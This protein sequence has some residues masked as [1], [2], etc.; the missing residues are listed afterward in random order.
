MTDVS[1]VSNENQ[2]SSADNSE[3]LFNDPDEMRDA[4]MSYARAGFACVPT[5]FMVE[6]P[7]GPECSCLEWERKRG[8]LAPLP[9]TQPAKHPRVK[10]KFDDDGNPKKD[11]DEG[12]VRR[13][14]DG[15]HRSANI[16]LKTG[17]AHG[18]FVVDYDGEDG[19][20][21]WEEYKAANGLADI[22]TPED[23][24]GS[25]KGG[26]VFF[27][28]SGTEIPNSASLLAPHVDTRGESGLIYVAP[29]NHKSGGKY[30]W[31][32]GRALG[33]KPLAPLPQCIIDDLAKKRPAGTDAKVP[34]KRVSGQES[35]RYIDDFERAGTK[36][37]TRAN[38]L[39]E[40]LALIGDGEGQAGFDRPI[41]SA[42]SSFFVHN[43]T[44]A[45]AEDIKEILRA[46]ILAAECHN[47][48]AEGR[49]ATDRYLDPR[50]EQARDFIIKSD[51]ER[52]ALA[53]NELEALQERVKT[54]GLSTPAAK[55]DSTFKHLADIAD[56]APPGLLDAVAKALGKAGGATP[57]QAVKR[58]KG[59]VDARRK[60]QAKAE[61]EAQR[62]KTNEASVRNLATKPTLRVNEDDFDYMVSTAWAR[63]RAVNDVEQLFF[64]IGGEKFRLDAPGDDG[65]I[66]PRPMDS[67][68]IWSEL[69][70]HVR[71]IKCDANQGLNQQRS[72]G[73]GL[74]LLNEGDRE[75]SGDHRSHELL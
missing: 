48:R 10:W 1:S 58:L 5:H 39:D 38:G 18:L 61:A 36:L 47:G 8:N 37:A 75:I 14:W 28:Y 3:F 13:N 4:A 59:L 67:T 7:L 62:Y 56:D 6:G 63:L 23:V 70:Q 52:A 21:A 27:A 40:H 20:R 43:G 68:V 55:I 30:C 73:A 44:D 34:S 12:Q 72:A 15:K 71:W 17:S 65:R 24:S 54:F 41:L 64:E 74:R 49:Y 2:R 42:A 53:K 32:G 57:A 25:G 26:H 29:S 16:A 45:S 69:N 11:W 35:V 9:C 19:K 50:I 66:V 60:E 22:I 46:A 31:I 51:E 33:E